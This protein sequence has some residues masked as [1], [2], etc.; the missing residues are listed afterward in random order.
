M[1][2]S[3]PLA[4]LFAAL[5]L[6]ASADCFAEYKAKRDDPLRLHYGIMALP[7]PCPDRRA[8]AGALAPRL[9]AAGWTLLDVVAL[10][11]TQPTDEMQANAGQH[12][13]RY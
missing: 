12:Y 1:R 13:L 6:P 2:R 5:A 7:A 9:A 8:A 10:S 11:T 4:A 3:L